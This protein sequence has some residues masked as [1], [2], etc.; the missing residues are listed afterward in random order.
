MLEKH[1]G[2]Q[3]IYKAA[4]G[5]V[6]EADKDLE[7]VTLT[8]ADLAVLPVEWL[9]EFSQMLR[10]GRSDLSMDLIGRIPPEHADLAQSLAELTRFHRLDK[11]IPITREALKEKDNNG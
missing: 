4:A 3:F 11:L 8:P 2:V 6:A 1:L 9:K 5:G 10:R 7:R